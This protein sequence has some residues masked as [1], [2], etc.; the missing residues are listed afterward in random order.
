VCF[1]RVIQD[2][3]PVVTLICAF[4]IQI[5]PQVDLYLSPSG[6]SRSLHGVSC[7][8]F[9]DVSGRIFDP[10]IGVQDKLVVRMNI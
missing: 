7:L 6:A 2:I 8:K 10:I 4:C 1:A 3:N 9:T 5:I